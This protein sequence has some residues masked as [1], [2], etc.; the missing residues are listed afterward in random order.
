MYGSV[1]DE[2]ATGDRMLRLAWHL[3]PW[4]SKLFP[5]LAPVDTLL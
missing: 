1:A 4:H 3:T 5:Q 2:S